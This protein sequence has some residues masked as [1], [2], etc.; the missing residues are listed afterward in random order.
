MIA[1]FSSKKTV[2][3]NKALKMAEELQ[4]KLIWVPGTSN[5]MD[6]IVEFFQTTSLYQDELL[7]LLNNQN[8][9]P[10]FKDEKKQKFFQDFR[11]FLYNTGRSDYGWNR[12]KIGEAPSASSV[13]INLKVPYDEL[14]STRNVSTHL[15]RRNNP[16][17]EVDYALKQGS[18]GKWNETE[19]IENEFVNPFMKDNYKFLNETLK[20]FKAN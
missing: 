14:F 7:Q 12:T 5:G 15:S 4:Q 2:I 1:I 19:I 13:Y 18:L 6:K 11:K 10:H 8:E 17:G 9:E 3:F 20:N 16:K